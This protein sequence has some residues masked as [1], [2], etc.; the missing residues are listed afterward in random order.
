MY[1]SIY[2]RRGGRGCGR[3][4][5]WVQLATAAGALIVTALPAAYAAD[6]QPSVQEVTVTGTRIRQQTGMN[7]PVPVTTHNTSDLAAFKPGA[8]I[9]DQLDKL[10]QLVQTESAQRGSGALFGNAGGTYLNLRGLE[11][12]RTLVLLDGSRIVQD[13][14]GGTVNVG[15]FP[16]AL[17]ERVDI[18]TGGAS[19]VYGADA[20]GGVVNVI[21][22][23]DF[24]G[25]ESRFRSSIAEG[26][27]ARELQLGHTMGVAWSTGHAVLSAEYYQRDPL[28]SADREQT[29][30]SDLRALGGTDHR[31]QFAHPGNI[32]AYSAAAGAYLPLYAIPTKSTGLTPA[33][34]V[35]GKINLGDFRQGADTL[36]KQERTSL[37][38]SVTQSVGQ[39]EL[40]A[41]AL[42]TRRRYSF[43]QGGTSTI[44]TVTNA[45]P[46]FV[47]IGGETS[48]LIAYDFVGAF[49]SQRLN[50]VAENL[51]LSAGAARDFGRTWRAEL[52][53][54]YSTDEATRFQNHFLNGTFLR[55]AL[56]SVPDNPATSYSA[57]R[58]GYFNPYGDGSNNNKAVIDFIDSGYQQHWRRNRVS[59]ANLKVD[60]TLIELPGGAL[61]LAAGGQLRKEDFLI[62]NTYLTSGVTPTGDGGTL[63]ERDVRS[64]FGELRVPLIGAHQDIPGVRSLE[65]SLAGRIEHYS[66]FGTT[67]NPKVGVLWEPVEGVKLRTSYGTSFRAPTLADIYEPFVISA[68]FVP[69][70]SGSTLSLAL[71]G[72]NL[73][74]QPETAKS[75]TTGVDF[76]P[77]N[78]PGARLGITY[79]DTRFSNQVGHPVYEDILNALKNP[80]YSAFVRRLNPNN[81]AD[82][83]AAQALIDA[84][85]SSTPKLFPANAYGTII[86]ARNVNAGE[87]DVRGLDVTANWP[88]Q[89]QDE[90]IDLSA[91]VSYLFEY[92]RRISPTAPSA[93]YV[94]QAGFPVD[95]RALLG[96][97]WTHGPFMTNLQVRYV[98]SYKSA[99]GARIGS[100]TTADVL[101]RWTSPSKDGWLT[102]LSATLSAQ[103][104]LGTRAP[105]YDSLDGVGYDPANADVL[106]RVVAV[107]LS[108]RW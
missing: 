74:L 73:G 36:P 38:A 19:A 9:G 28:S 61:K 81:A 48:Q 18:V 37:Y 80:I 82:V 78:H 43:L 65:L 103:N 89:V 88:V 14:R 42:Y 70:V 41:D 15:V 31:T 10:P 35:S 34:F 27:E 62:R 64:A 53:G 67:K 90:K 4:W 21:L 56:G 102:N 104:V 32:V 98:D 6:D 26:G 83:A 3:N 63:F 57:A 96:A 47:S 91:N 58:D 59:S 69:D 30:S 97:S 66:D 7:T 29:A 94:N 93:D 50:G 20:V 84:S 107:S 105:F 23:R 44:I 101:V 72:G 5:Q 52:Y 49:G 45:N 22:R 13:D 108:K 51:G 25:Q 46:Y 106:G 40:S 60:G 99:A 71:T 55:E 11:S 1:E 92:S 54:A 68:A 86:D 87:L 75:W 24:T 77:V 17:L 79:F 95:L 12:K 85:T 33:D 8:S 100:W 39:V 76:T 2:A 16:T